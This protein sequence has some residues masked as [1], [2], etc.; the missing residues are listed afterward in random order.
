MPIDHILAV[1]LAGMAALVAGSFMLFYRYRA[2]R[3]AAAVAGL[4]VLFEDRHLA[5]MGLDAFPKH[6]LTLPPN[7][8]AISR[9]RQLALDSGKAAVFLPGQTLQVVF[10]PEIQKGLQNG[11]YTLMKTK[12]GE[13]LADAV[14]TSSSKIVGKGRLTQSGKVRQFAAAGFQLVSIAVAQAHLAE[15]AEGMRA[16]NTKL[17]SITNRLEANDIAEIR[18]SIDYVR[19]IATVVHENHDPQALSSEMAQNLEATIR[20]SHTWLQKLLGHLTELVKEARALEDLD[21][22]GTGKTFDALKDIV[23]RARALA[24]RRAFYSDFTSTVN[25]LTSYIDPKRTRFTQA[26]TTSQEWDQLMQTLATV[27]AKKAS[28]L[29]KDDVVFNRESTLSSRRSEVNK[30]LDA[31]TAEAREVNTQS[32]ARTARI[33][34]TLAAL[35]APDKPVRLALTF[36]AKGEVV[37]AGLLP[38]DS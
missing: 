23:S 27:L 13:T 25:L 18:G 14:S 22:F 2:R 34:H 21:T 15:I 3:R 29:F 11:A 30:E 9:L 31:L 5:V 28:E 24:D 16:L 4:A 20:H 26:Q 7:S 37:E 6:A 1:E 10:K 8:P 35:Q 38:V 32:S 19:S 33:E 36:D 12:Q 17:D